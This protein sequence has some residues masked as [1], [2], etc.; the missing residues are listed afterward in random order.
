MDRLL[1]PVIKYIISEIYQDI[2]KQT[3]FFLPEIG[4]S[5]GIIYEVICGECS[6]HIRQYVRRKRRE[7]LLLWTIELL[8]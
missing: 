1:P 2:I 3:V 8:N 6:H 7:I 4:V 5:E